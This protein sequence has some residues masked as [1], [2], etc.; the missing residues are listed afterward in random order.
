MEESKAHKGSMVLADKGYASA[1][2][3]IS[4]ER[5]GITDGIM[6]KAAKLQPALN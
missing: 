5:A 3:R 6:Y 4:L 2:N 1:D